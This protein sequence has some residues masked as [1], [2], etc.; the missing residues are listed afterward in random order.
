VAGAGRKENRSLKAAQVAASKL[1]EA[2]HEIKAIKSHHDQSADKCK[3]W[4]LPSP[5]TVDISDLM[6]NS[7]TCCGEKVG[8]NGWRFHS[9]LIGCDRYTSILV[10]R[11]HMLDPSVDPPQ[12]SRSSREWATDPTETRLLQ[13]L[14]LMAARTS[15]PLMISSVKT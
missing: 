14:G 15:K 13:C 7:G 8:T 12:V 6:S 10:S 5:L 2:A 9:V 11:I 4:A 3:T 1:D